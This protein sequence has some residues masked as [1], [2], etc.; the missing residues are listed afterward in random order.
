MENTVR[1]EVGYNLV[2]KSLVGKKFEE[3]EE[4]MSIIE[5]LRRVNHKQPIKQTIAITGLE[6]FLSSTNEAEKF[7]RALLSTSANLLRTHVIQFIIDGYLVMNAEPKIKFLNHEIRLTPIFGNRLT[8]K[9]IGYF[10]SPP[11][12]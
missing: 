5:F 10:H 7:T 12:I 8:M 2:E 11:N 6:E 9:A 4:K 1:M 3:I